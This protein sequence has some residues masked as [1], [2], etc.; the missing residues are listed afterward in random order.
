MIAPAATVAAALAAITATTTKAT[1]ERPWMAWMR[2]FH[3]RGQDPDFPV[4]A[5]QLCD[6]KKT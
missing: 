2:G 6:V 1:K 5:W 4:T 3:L